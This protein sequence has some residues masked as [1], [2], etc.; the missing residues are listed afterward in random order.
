MVIARQ[1]A[2]ETSLEYAHCDCDN[3]QADDRQY[4]EQFSYPLKPRA[5]LHMSNCQA[6]HNRA[7]GR[8]EQ[9]H[10]A[11][12]GAENHDH[13]LDREVQLAGQTAHAAKGPMMGMDTVAMPELDGIKNESTT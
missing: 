11:I 5:I 7:A 2:G 13:G 3:H 9:V 12:C 8:S 10:E 4:R 6:T 1:R